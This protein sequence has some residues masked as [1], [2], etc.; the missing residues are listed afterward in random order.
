MLLGLSDD[1]KK[2]YSLLSGFIDMAQIVP[3]GSLAQCGDQTA[4]SLYLLSPDS[5]P[6]IFIGSWR[7]KYRSKQHRIVPEVK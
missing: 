2:K 6:V 5:P 7:S 3:K 4:D 1:P